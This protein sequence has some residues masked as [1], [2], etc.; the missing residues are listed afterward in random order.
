MIRKSFEL[1]WEHTSDHDNK[2][3]AQTSVNKL[4]EF[5]FI[6]NAIIK[7]CDA[8]G[9]TFIIKLNEDIIDNDIL[10]TNFAENVSILKKCGI[11]VVVVHEHGKLVEETLKNFG[12]EDKFIN[13]SRVTDHKTAKLVEMVVSGFINKKIVS[14]LCSYDCKAIGISGKDANMIQAHNVRVSKKRDDNC[15]SVIDFG[16]IGEPEMINPEILVEFED[17]GIIPVISPIA[18]GANGSTY[19]LDTDLTA[20]IIASALSAEKLIFFNQ[21]GAL[22]SGEDVISELQIDELKSLLNKN[23]VDARQVNMAEAAVSAIDNAASIVHILNSNKKDAI[24]IDIF[25]DSRDG[26]LVSCF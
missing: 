19:L 15:D 1:V 10:L 6:K 5:D 23:K 24:L 2:T 17:A 16:F 4:T 18:Y 22:I 3:Q 8:R 7:A 13:G 9:E 20:A 14:K 11:N 21:Q 26:S 12:I 25:T